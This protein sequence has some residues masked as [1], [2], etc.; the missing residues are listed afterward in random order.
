MH[1]LGYPS[2]EYIR[3]ANAAGFSE[4]DIL[5]QA[6][7]ATAP[8]KFCTGSSRFGPATFATITDR[9]VLNN[10]AAAGQGI[11]LDYEV[12]D[13][14][15]ASETRA[16]IEDL[17]STI[18]AKGKKIILY[19]NASG[20]AARSPSTVIGHSACPPSV[21]ATAIEYGMI[22]ATTGHA[23]VAI[24]STIKNEL[25]GTLTS[26]FGRAFAGKRLSRA[27]PHPLSGAATIRAASGP[28]PIRVPSRPL[29][30][31]WPPQPAQG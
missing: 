2:S 1:L 18:H 14:R 3:V 7:I 20:S 19:T 9:I 24:M 23:L 27:D 29:D 30:A 28:S 6:T 12:Q 31:G 21:K 8:D 15:T 25:N 11:M 17:A 13:G 5:S 16:F 10:T 4:T 22:A 26:N